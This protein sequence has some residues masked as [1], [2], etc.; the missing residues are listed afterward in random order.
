[1]A[2]LVSTIALVVIIESKDFCEEYR[3]N[4]YKIGFAMSLHTDRGYPDDIILLFIGNTYWKLSIID[5][6]ID[7]LRIKN[8]T[9]E[10]VS[11]GTSNWLSSDKYYTVL[12]PI[13]H[14]DKDRDNCL[15]GALQKDMHTIDWANTLCVDMNVHNWINSTIITF[16]DNNFKPDLLWMLWR[17]KEFSLYMTFANNTKNIKYLVNQSIHSIEVK[18]SFRKNDW[19]NDQYINNNNI[20]ALSHRYDHILKSIIFMNVNKTIQYC[21]DIDYSFPSCSAEYIKTMIDCSP[22]SNRLMIIIIVIFIVIV[23]IAIVKLIL[24]YRLYQPMF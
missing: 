11:A 16:P 9:I 2:L 13:I 1:M 24:Y 6:S 18:S 10:T 8:I 14:R 12:P 19:S 22:Q 5:A 20:I 15:Y 21:Y 23:V 17:V 4:D 7:S 3:K